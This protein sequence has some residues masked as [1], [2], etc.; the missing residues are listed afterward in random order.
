[1]HARFFIGIIKS[2]TQYVSYIDGNLPSKNYFQKGFWLYFGRFP[3]NTTLL[4]YSSG[5]SDLFVGYS[6]EIVRY[7]G[8]IWALFQVRVWVR[9]KYHVFRIRVQADK[10]AKLSQVY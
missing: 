6:I 4:S 9:Q 8:Q 1:M 7:F 10:N 3:T 5:T 2:I